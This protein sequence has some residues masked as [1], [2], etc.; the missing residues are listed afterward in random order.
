MSD[1]LNPLVARRR[2]RIELRNARQGAGYTQ[3][4]VAAA[5]EWSLSKLIRIE[6]GSVGITTNDLRAL[7][8][9]YAIKDPGRTAELLA[10]GRA[11]REKPWWSEHR[12]LISPQLGMLID[13]ESTATIIRSFQPLLIPGLLQTEA[14]AR[15]AISQFSAP[16]TPDRLDNVV[17]IRMRRQEILSRRDGPK[18]L[19][20]LDEA[21]IRRNVGGSRVMREQI[22]HLASMASRRNVSIEIVPFNAGIHPGLQGPF[23]VLEFPD[24]ADNDLLFLESSRGDLF[25]R[26]DVDEVASY[27]EKFEQL[28]KMSIDS[29]ETIAYLSQAADELK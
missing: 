14:Y 22:S 26:D 4:Q 19:A 28:R 27:Q 23:V 6:S 21:A 16:S 7:L 25:I 10:L 1:D 13:Y 11:S 12:D 15:A 24:P 18:L 20:V 2:L 8:R 29:S 3:E 9:Y 5:M 17:K